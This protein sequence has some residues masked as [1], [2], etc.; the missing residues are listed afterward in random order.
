MKKICFVV[1][2]ANTARTF[3]SNHFRKIGNDFEIHLVSNDTKYSLSDLNV[4]FIKV[5]PIY[6]K[7]NLYNDI[8]SVVKMI[9]YFRSERFDLVCSVTPKA[10][11][12]TALSSYISGVNYRIHVFTG[13]VWYTKSGLMRLLLKSLDRLIGALCTSVLV[14]GYSQLDFLLKNNVLIQ[15]KATVLGNG[16]LAGVDTE[17]FKPSEKVRDAVRLSLGV[18]SDDVIFMFLGRIN[19]DKG[20]FE[21]VEAFNGL[22]KDYSKNIFL[23]FVGPLEIDI[24]P[25][26]DLMLNKEKV[27]FLGPT[28]S[29]EKIIQACDIFCLP[30]FR[31]GF[32][33][34]IIEASALGKAVI[35]SDTYGLRDSFVP[36]VTGLEHSTGDVKSLQEK[37]LILLNNENLRKNLGNSGRRRVIEKFETNKLSELWVNYIK[38]L[39]S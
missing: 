23:V 18:S 29:P 10:G 33:N 38:S 26:I 16:S 6:R 3:L 28:N 32:G 22:L 37:M 11:L 12:L 13:Q 9:K 14:D 39:I 20:V 5:V 8:L 27:I 15:G 34:A 31:E 7:I 35:C 24:G 19:Y 17:I 1:A 2:D 30:S 25:I 4:N 36:D 21:L